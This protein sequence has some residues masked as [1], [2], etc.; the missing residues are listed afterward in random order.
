MIDFDFPPLDRHQPS[1]AVTPKDSDELWTVL[2]E[3][4]VEPGYADSYVTEAAFEVDVWRRVVALAMHLGL[5]EHNACLTSHAYHVDR[6]AAAW[7][8]FS[9]EESGP[10]VNVLGA[11]NRLDII[12]RHPECGSIGIEVKCLGANGHARK[13]TQGLGQALLGLANRDRTVLLIHCGTV[14]VKERERLRGVGDRIFDG[15]KTGLIVVP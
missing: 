8:A 13:L 6:S 14:D 15:L 4:L 9:K 10:D 5:D 1:K 3:R 11:N 7:K 12:L 2:R